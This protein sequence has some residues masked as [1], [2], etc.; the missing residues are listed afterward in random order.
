MLATAPALRPVISWH[1]V[2]WLWTLHLHDS[3][4]VTRYLRWTE[5]GMADCLSIRPHQKARASRGTLP[6]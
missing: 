2:A 4:T 5:H 3:L 6:T 1:P